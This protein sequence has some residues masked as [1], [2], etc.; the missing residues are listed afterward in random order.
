METTRETFWAIARIHRDRAW[1]TQIELGTI[2]D[3]L[4]DAEAP[5]SDVERWWYLQGQVEAFAAIMT[6]MESSR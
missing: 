6:E 5:L 3:L 1:D 4:A 2:C